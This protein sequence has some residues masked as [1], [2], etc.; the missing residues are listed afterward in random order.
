MTWEELTE[1]LTE[2]ADE[3]D[4]KIHVTHQHGLDAV[5]LHF[6]PV[7]YF[8][9][10]KF[11]GVLNIGTYEGEEKR[12]VPTEQIPL[13]ELTLEFVH[14]RVQAAAREQFVT[15]L[16]FDAVREMMQQLARPPLRDVQG[17]GE[18]G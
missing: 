9:S 2:L 18:G 6:V 5:A 15:S 16:D 12:L 14:E 11:T 4:K 13:P 3:Y 7:A 8:I 17:A 10:M 1:L